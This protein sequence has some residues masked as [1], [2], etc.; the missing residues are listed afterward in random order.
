M[1]TWIPNL[2]THSPIGIYTKIGKKLQD[3]IWRNTA[4]EKAVEAISSAL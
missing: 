1:T 2:G 3:A 4:P